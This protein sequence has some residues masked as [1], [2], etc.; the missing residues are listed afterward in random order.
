[1]PSGCTTCDGVNAMLTWFKGWLKQPFSAD[2]DTLHWFLFL[3][4]VILIS[5]AWRNL[6][7]SHILEGLE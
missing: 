1:M 5:F 7:L 2:M 3:G 6:I 4:L